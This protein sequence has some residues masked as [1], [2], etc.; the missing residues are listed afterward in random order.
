MPF[1]FLSH[2]CWH[3]P[4]GL[5][6]RSPEAGSALPPTNHSGEQAPRATLTPP[7]ISSFF[8]LH[9]ISPFQAPGDQPVPPPP[10]LAA[11]GFICRN[12][13]T[14]S[15]PRPNEAS[16]IGREGCGIWQKPGLG[17]GDGWIS[18]ALEGLS[19]SGGIHSSIQLPPDLALGGMEN[20]FHGE[21]CWL[22]CWGS[23]RRGLGCC[24]SPCHWDHLEEGQPSHAK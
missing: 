19:S 8:L 4:V 12:L 1:L 10:Q 5:K 20:Q 22:R 11:L 6:A 7:L 3:L 18:L 16:P 2:P 9:S 23:C 13:T 24:P 17:G 21:L 14:G 15:F